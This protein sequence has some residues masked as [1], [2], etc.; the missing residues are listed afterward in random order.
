MKNLVIDCNVFI[1]AFIGSDTCFKAIDK[2]FSDYRV[3]YSD[4]TLKELLET[5]KRPKF[6]HLRKAQRIETTLQVLH[7][8]GAFYMPKSC[9]IELPDPDDTIYLDLAITANA[10]FIITGNKKHF[11]ENLCEGIKILSPSEFLK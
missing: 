11:P 1:S 3:C 6:Q 10:E 9:N 7:S 8:L 2:A 5:L 4:A